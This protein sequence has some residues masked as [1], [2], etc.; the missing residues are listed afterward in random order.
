MSL[1]YTFSTVYS[2]KLMDPA[3]KK[4]SFTFIVIFHLQ[5]ALAVKG[6]STIEKE[7][8]Y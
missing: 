7:S 3:I 2:K 6:L 1:V 8:K 5:I 4:F